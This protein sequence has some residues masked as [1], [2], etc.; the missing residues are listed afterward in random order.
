MQ[1]QD[2]SAA[3][4]IV[5]KRLSLAPDDLEALAWHARILS[6]QGDWERAENEYRAVLSHH[7]A[8][9]DVLLGLADVLIWQQK[10]EMALEPIDRA[11]RAGASRIDI[12]RRRAHCL[13]ALGRRREASA[14][15]REWLAVDPSN[16][17]A[18]SALGHGERETRHELRIGNDTDF[19]NYTGTASAETSTLRSRWNSRWT[20]VF[21][22]SFYQR[23]G[24]DARKVNGA[25]TIGLDAHNYVTLGGAVANQQDVISRYDQ[26]FAYG[27]GFA[28][29]AAFIRGLEVSAE[30]RS[31]W[32]TSS[33]VT[34]VGGSLI[35]YLPRDWQW[36]LGT[37]GVRSR[38]E[39]AGS[40][41]SP[42]GTT[43]LSFPI[44]RRVGGHVSFAL[45]SE[46]YSNIDQIGRFSAHTYGGGVRVHLTS[47]QE[48]SLNGAWQNRTQ[49]RT[50]TSMGV[51]YA[52]RF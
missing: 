18:K 3:L 20:T 35:L 44:T 40:A 49:N 31:L 33:Q 7:P 16:A 30:E 42:S 41:W 1:H 9:V 45:G 8:D 27:R 15:Y 22:G 23:F 46:D 28:L 2:L 39:S 17:E 37:Y 34:L 6:W 51:S 5:N 38:F 4:V 50:Q 36:S 19:F 14:V 43:R 12:L 21:G 52:V 26:S 29:R 24:A 48:V 32:F 13:T 11:A 47:S 25:V 10:F